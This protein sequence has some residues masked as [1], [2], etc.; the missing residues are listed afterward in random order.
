MDTEELMKK[1]E[2]YIPRVFIVATIFFMS[3]VGVFGWFIGQIKE[4]ITDETQ[5]NSIQK[6]LPYFFCVIFG[7]YIIIIIICLVSYL[8]NR[9]K[10]PVNEF[11]GKIDAFIVDQDEKERDKKF[12][13]INKNVQKTYWVLGISL[14]SMVDRE[15]VLKKMASNSVNIK[16]CMLNPDITIENLCKESMDQKVC[17]VKNI[18]QSNQAEDAQPIDI[19]K[20][21]EEVC[22]VEC[23]QDLLKLYNVL[24]NTTHFSEYY[25]TATDYGGTV[26]KS[27]ENL[28][29]IQNKILSEN[30]NAK[31]EL[32]LSD[33]F[34]PISLTIADAQEEY[35][36]MVVEFHLPFMHYKVL[37]QIN[38]SENRDL[39]EVLLDFYE[40]VWAR[41]SKKA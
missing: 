26:K 14:T 12:D 40:K 36:K 10:V 4:T 41:S 39:F 32:K 34:M 33:S 3:F 22:K 27:Y 31:F 25:D 19:M 38:K 23:D 29:R 18:I 21:D 30:E 16:L 20:I 17:I 28:K 37:F 2:K 24:M 35:G 15:Q 11:K 7:V 1:A 9:K 8:R 13:D 5:W 6:L